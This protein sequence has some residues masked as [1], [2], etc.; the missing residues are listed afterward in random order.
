M[1]A[2]AW[3]PARAPP[4]HAWVTG[5]RCQ[6]PVPRGVPPA[7]AAPEVRSPSP[8]QGF[9]YGHRCRPSLRHTR[10]KIVSCRAAGGAGQGRAEWQVKMVGGSG[11]HWHA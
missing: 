9:S 5:G 8:L 1:G 2:A 11:R 10:L 3:L 4:A 7:R 6:E